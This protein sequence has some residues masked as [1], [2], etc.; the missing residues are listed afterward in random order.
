V[1]GAG[2]TVGS[3]TQGI[4]EAYNDAAKSGAGIR[5][6]LMPFT[7]DLSTYTVRSTVFIK[8]NKS[9][10]DGY[11]ARV[12]CTTR[13]RCIALGTLA[14]GQLEGIVQGIEFEPGINVD[15]VNI[16]SVKAN[17][18]VYT[19]TTTTAHPFVDTDTII[20]FYSTSAQ[21]QESR[22]NPTFNSVHT[23]ASCVNGTAGA[24]ACTT[25]E[26]EY[27]IGSS[28]TF[29]SSAGYGW[30]NISN[31]AVEDLNNH[32]RLQ[33][34]H[35][36]T[37]NTNRFSWGAVINN[38]Q[39]AVIDG[40]SIASG[41]AIKCATSGFCG[42]GLYFRGDQGISPV[43][44]VTNSQFSLGCS[45][46]GIRYAA[47]NGLHIERTVAQGFS[48]Y[49]TYYK[50]GLQPWTAGP[51]SYEESGACANFKYP[52]GG[53]LI[54]AQMGYF[55]G[56]PK[57]SIV[58][59]TAIAGDF[60]SFVA[61]NVGAQQNNYYIIIK[62]GGAVASPALYIGKCL[63]QITGNCTVYWPEPNL[64]M[65]GGAAVTYDLLKVIGTAVV[66]PYAG[67]ANSVSTGITRASACTA[68]TGICSFV[69]TQSGTSAYTM[70][71]QTINTLF[72]FWPAAVVLSNA[73]KLEMAGACGGASF[74][75][76]TFVP[77][78]S[79]GTNSATSGTSNGTFSPVFE[80]TAT[81]GIGAN[82]GACLRERQAGTGGL[83]GL[84]G[85][86]DFNAIPQGDLFT[87]SDSNYQKT[88]A[89]PNHRP[90]ADAADSAIGFDNAQGAA[91]SVAQLAFRAPVA[92]SEYINSPFD[93]A[94]W[95]R[96][97]TATQLTLN[98]ANTV[99]LQPATALGGTFGF[100][101]F[102]LTTPATT[103]CLS[104]VGGNMTSINGVFS[105][106]GGVAT[107]VSGYPPN[108]AISVCTS[109]SFTAN[110]S[111][112]IQTVTVGAGNI[113]LV[114][115]SSTTPANYQ[116]YEVFVS[117][118]TWFIYKS[119]AAGTRTQLATGPGTFPGAGHYLTGI[120]SGTTSVTISAYYDGTLLGTATDASSPI[121]S[122]NPGIFSTS[123]VGAAGSMIAI[124]QAFTSGADLTNNGALTQNGNVTNNG[125]VTQVGNLI[126]SS[127][128]TA[129]DTYT[130]INKIVQ[131]GV[132]VCRAAA[133]A[134]GDIC[135][136][137]NACYAGTIG[138]GITSTSAGIIDARDYPVRS[139]QV[140][141]SNPFAGGNRGGLLL[142]GNYNIYTSKTII[143]PQKKMRILGVGQGSPLGTNGKTTSAENTEIHP[144]TGANAPVTGCAASIQQ[145]SNKLFVEP[146]YTISTCTEVGTTA[147]CTTTTNHNYTFTTS[148]P[149][150]RSHVIVAGNSVPGY[151][152]GGANPAFFK[153]TAVGPSCPTTCNQISF[154][155]ASAV[156]GTGN[157]G[158][159]TEPA[160]QHGRFSA[161]G[162]GLTNAGDY[163]ALIAMG[164]QLNAAGYDGLDTCGT[165]P[166]GA[167][168]TLSAFGSTLE[169]LSISNDGVAGLQSVYSGNI[170]ERGG[171]K[172][173]TFQNYGGLL[174]GNAEESAIMFD[175]N[176]WN[177]NDACSNSSGNGG[178]S[179]FII[180][181]IFCD[182]SPV[183]NP[184]GPGASDQSGVCVQLAGNHA[185]SD[186]TSVEDGGGVGGLAQYGITGGGTIRGLND[187]GKGK[188]NY[189]IWA[190]NYD[191]GS[192]VGYHF[193]N[194]FH[195]PFYLHGINGWTS[196]GW[197]VGD[198]DF[199]S[200][201]GTCADYVPTGCADVHYATGTDANIAINVRGASGATP[202]AVRDDVNGCGVA[203]GA[204]APCIINGL[205]DGNPMSL[206]VQGL[207]NVYNGIFWGDQ[208]SGSNP[209][210][211]SGTGAPSAACVSGSEWL[212]TDGA[213]NDYDCVNSV[214][215]QRPEYDASG[216]L[217]IPG[218]LTVATPGGGVGSQ[219]FLTSEGTAPTG[220]VTAGQ[221]NCYADS[222][223]HGILCSFNARPMRYLLRSAEPSN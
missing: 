153:L 126:L 205:T 57:L 27:T 216:N 186:G 122:G 144:C 213:I 47:G 89:T 195:D 92:I 88:L 136:D 113:G 79:C 34:I 172:D 184:T 16:S 65:N 83:K 2:F 125:S 48:E 119:N 41:T 161:T 39:A 141:N 38:D 26:F 11:G 128:N 208:A 35:V 85:Q 99:F 22:V 28:S 196:K 102:N 221:D 50:G 46:N 120:V 96:R 90:A 158:S 30:A 152:S 25:T 4:Q 68:S 87:L 56:S 51:N 107:V 78:V 97:Q 203:F 93:N 72:N 197:H 95:L 59:N 223:A 114:L 206:Y 69:D 191:D 104:G 62:S 169:H 175:R 74:V 146:T 202:A 86:I 36:I 194:I 145:A 193:E 181:H 160:R 101:P 112:Q 31:T 130:D 109:A 71:G 143:T 60:P 147:T 121:A 3:S 217:S 219:V 164:G 137:I 98:S 222:T 105:Y 76:S 40:F 66:P 168:W 43:G 100:G 207:M 210:T 8:T 129:E 132:G 91:A 73:S 142:L 162:S 32:G 23:G 55:S 49:G 215:V 187:G 157:G 155:V 12:L 182:A 199:A 201:S 42:A 45:G 82:G 84:F 24:G 53:G 174:A 134:S 131:S 204:A 108:P 190:E 29:A 209:Y 110:Q 188:S 139:N 127:K 149:A 171:F 15:G 13:D 185:E 151:N 178:P 111:A 117:A 211:K 75:T 133:R 61:Q 115:R 20:F 154:T 165:G 179:H 176:S 166:V 220:T 124:S 52:Q 150:I 135:A 70:V 6:K 77:S 58:D 10:L 64:E 123:T 198:I 192:L 218:N 167:N 212:R 5:V 200:S 106:S 118:S 54:R 183:S 19:V 170:Q 44:W 33:D 138:P 9:V 80:Q 1:H 189:G 81:C 67:N 14:G 63:T 17:T 116:H 103:N 159:V 21:T 180:D 173:V 37:G 7:G 94:S 140:C 177:L 18:G 214:W 156:L 163:Y 148:S